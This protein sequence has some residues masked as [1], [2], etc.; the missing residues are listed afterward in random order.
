MRAFL[1]ILA[2]FLPVHTQA[3]T[4]YQ[5]TLDRHGCHVCLYNCPQQQLDYGEYH[6][7]YSDGRT[8]HHSHP[9]AR[10]SRVFPTP[11]AIKYRNDKDT[12]AHS[13]LTRDDLRPK[14]RR[15]LRLQG[16]TAAF[17]HLRNIRTGKLW[18]GRALLNTAVRG[19]QRG[20]RPLGS[21]R[22]SNARPELAQVTHVINAQTLDVRL[23][24]GEQ[25]I[26]RIAGIEA[27]RRALQGQRSQCHATTSEVF[28]QRLLA[29]QPVTLTRLYNLG[30]LSEG[31][32][33][34]YVNLRGQD[35]G[36]LLLREGIV[37][38]TQENHLYSAEYARVQ[39]QAKRL[40]KGLWRDCIGA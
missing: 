1:L 14:K 8:P 4:N 18:R 30:S 3:A 9:R 28:V 35:I 7:H 13:T 34:A 39:E 29:R 21:F 40:D 5:P 20:D 12:A 37:F 23:P 19:F 33:Y 16:S 32:V 31:L 36:S 2:V 27:P 24:N 26:V 11:Y 10:R 38:T 6:C 17:E 25:V 15:S 22:N